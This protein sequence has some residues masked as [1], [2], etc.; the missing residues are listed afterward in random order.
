MSLRAAALAGGG[1]G[2]GVAPFPGYISGAWYP[3]YLS[4]AA[5]FGDTGNNTVLTLALEYIPQSV[6][7]SEIGCRIVTA[8][9]GN[10][11]VGIYAHNSATG[12]PTGLAL[13]SVTGLSTASAATVT[14]VLGTPVTLSA[15]FYWMASEM[16]NALATFAVMALGGYSMNTVV[17]SSAAATSAGAGNL[18]GWTTT[19]TYGTFPDLTAA[20]LTATNTNQAALIMHRV[21]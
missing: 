13:A 15:G 20:S 8:S 4:Q 12:K 5:A 3:P 9:A 10:A 21:A 16:D 2:G 18:R 6:T 19:N 14:A 17:G 1:T 7:I 11:M